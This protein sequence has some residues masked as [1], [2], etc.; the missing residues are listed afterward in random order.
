MNDPA[1]SDPLWG[2]RLQTLWLFFTILYSEAGSLAPRRV[3]SSWMIL[4]AGILLLAV[5]AHVIVSSDLERIR[6]M[7]LVVLAASLFVANTAL[8][9]FKDKMAASFASLFAV[10]LASLLW[11]S[12][13]DNRFKGLQYAFFVSMSL[14]VVGGFLGLLATLG[15]KTLIAVGWVS[16][17]FY[18]YAPMETATM[19]A[20][21]I[22][23]LLGGR[24]LSNRIAGYVPI[25][26][27]GTRAFFV[28]SAILS[29]ASGLTLAL[30]NRVRIAQWVGSIYRG[31]LFAGL[32]VA[33]FVLPIGFCL[34]YVHRKSRT[35]S[36]FSWR[37]FSL[38][39]L[40]GLTASILANALVS[41][42]A[43]SENL[44]NR[45]V[46]AEALTGLIVGSAIG[47][48]FLCVNR[49]SDTVMAKKDWS[50]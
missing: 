16:R 31:G 21:S 40:I 12:C 48:G 38:L 5:F 30:T 42:A 39:L 29:A 24:I 19:C 7:L 18:I 10:M 23:I 9:S 11:R 50:V 15:L 34:V 47:I 45:W 27:I 8:N 4:V 35:A 37:V 22:G 2:T 43:H 44:M 3:V 46:G 25:P 28:R 32:Y 20:F 14:A 33:C 36:L 26:P 13:I 41:A 49:L 6:R 17:G 1:F